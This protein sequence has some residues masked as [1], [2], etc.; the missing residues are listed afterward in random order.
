MKTEIKCSKCLSDKIVKSGFMNNK[1]RYR[2]KNCHYHF[3]LNDRRK[4]SL[5]KKRLAIHLYLEGLGFRSIERVL[6]ISNVI[7]MKW[8]NNISDT[9]KNIHLLSADDNSKTTITAVELDEMWHYVGKKNGDYGSGL[10]SIE[11]PVKSLRG[12]SVLVAKKLEKSSG[13]K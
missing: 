9:I 4:I 10:L 5:E 13:K 11:T 2:C 7:V 3:T 12:K 6:K 8:V 1:Q